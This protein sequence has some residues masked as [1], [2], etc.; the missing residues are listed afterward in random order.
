[1]TLPSGA[2]VASGVAEAEAERLVDS[3]AA[4]CDTALPRRSP[5]PR[6]RPPVYLWNDIVAAA[7]AECVRRKRLWIRRRGRA[8]D[9]GDP[10]ADVERAYRE[11]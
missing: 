6:G 4:A 9:G 10:A 8:H 2:P 11:A 1:M 3:V 7:R 5:H